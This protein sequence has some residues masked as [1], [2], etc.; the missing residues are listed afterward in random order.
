ML[1]FGL[2]ISGLDEL[3]KKLKDDE[4]K[5]NK[6]LAEALN[7][8]AIRGKDEVKKGVTE[9][10]TV[11]A[12]EVNGSMTTRKASQNRLE[13]EIRVFGNSR[14]FGR[15]LNVIR[16][17]ETSVTLAQ[18]KKR[19]KLG[20]LNQL[21][22]KFLKGSDK[23]IIPGA[24]IGNKGRTVFERTGDKRLPIKPVLVVGV[25]Q[26]LMHRNV[27]KTV[28]GRINKILKEELD[29]AMAGLEK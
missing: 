7:R 2:S 25:G 23:K 18:A 20:T 14:K 1:K 16:F 10:Y 4:K 13:S 26:M 28:L 3:K 29:K 8:T 22:F 11:K 19:L 27:H 12:S 5:R 17:M 6:A 15:S 24:F 21:H 9:R